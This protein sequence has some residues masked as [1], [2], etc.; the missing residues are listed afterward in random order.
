M[1]KRQKSFA[2]HQKA[3]LALKQAI[4]NEIKERKKSGRPLIVWK[5]GKVTR[6]S[7]K[8]L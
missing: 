3:E 1:I 4:R 6:L 8:N 5:N 2:L 7:T